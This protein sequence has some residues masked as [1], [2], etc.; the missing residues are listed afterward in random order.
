M[1]KKT[2]EKTCVFYVSDYHFEM[3]SLPFI[4]KNLESKKEVIVLTENDL[5]DTIKVLLSKVNLKDEKKKN[6]SKINWSQNS[7]I[8]FKQIKSNMENNKETI[9][10][11]KGDE[12]YIKNTNKKIEKL[13]K[14]NG[15]TKI[16][17]CYNLNEVNSNLSRIMSSYKNM[18]N[19]S[20]EINVENL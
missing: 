18:L 10:F 14:N 17:D 13:I 15:N 6:L 12:E 5:E 2:N 4:E 20:G 9:V 1:S 19:T 3:I 16:I 8:K 11:I 7:Q